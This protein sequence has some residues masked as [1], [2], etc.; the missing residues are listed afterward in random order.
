MP[1]RVELRC[2]AFSG[3]M[4]NLHEDV[5]P[6]GITGELQ[7]FWILHHWMHQQL[8]K[9]VGAHQELPSSSFNQE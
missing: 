7:G 4:H 6:A 9:H 8:V 3:K 1:R 5:R 2:Q